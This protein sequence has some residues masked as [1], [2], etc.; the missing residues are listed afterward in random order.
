MHKPKRKTAPTSSVKELRKY[1]KDTDYEE[2]K[3]SNSKDDFQIRYI[4][5]ILEKDLNKL[6]KNK[7]LIG[8]LGNDYKNNL[9]EIN[10][11]VAMTP[12][13]LVGLSIW[14][15]PKEVLQV[16]PKFWRM[17]KKYKL[18]KNKKNIPVCINNCLLD[19]LD[20]VFTMIKDVKTNNKV[21]KLNKTLFEK[22]EMLLKQTKLFLLIAPIFF[23]LSDKKTIKK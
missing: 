6:I 1:L 4:L 19:N 11:I 22:H 18:K 10:K 14:A 9:T 12:K 21:I 16:L 20:I 7:N 8:K 5:T 2:I 15:Y 23:E 3:V 13:P 17:F